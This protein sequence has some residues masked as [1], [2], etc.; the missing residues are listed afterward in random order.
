MEKNQQIESIFDLLPENFSEDDYWAAV[1]E[2]NEKLEQLRLSE[3]AAADL[4]REAYLK[5]WAGKFR[6]FFFRSDLSRQLA[7]DLR[8]ENK[9]L[10]KLDIIA[11]AARCGRLVDLPP[12]GLTEFQPAPLPALRGAPHTL[13][14]RLLP[15]PFPSF[16][17]N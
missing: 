7:R 8:N 13:S 5:G 10:L 3:V 11:T 16:C 6:R 1:Q 4:E 17:R 15:I 12:G 9:I 14:P 2:Y